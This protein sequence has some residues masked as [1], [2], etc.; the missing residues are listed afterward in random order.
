MLVHEPLGEEVGLAQKGGACPAEPTDHL[1]PGRGE[2]EQDAAIG[3]RGV[4]I[5]RARDLALLAGVLQS[6]GRRLVGAAFAVVPA[7][8]HGVPK[9]SASVAASAS[10]QTCRRSGAIRAIPASEKPVS[11]GAPTK[12]TMS[13][14]MAR[15]MAPSAS[16]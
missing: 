11:A 13:C 16:W 1:R 5:G 3:D 9:G 12:T 15:L 6:L 2:R 7:L 10:A 4:Q 14:G 8:H